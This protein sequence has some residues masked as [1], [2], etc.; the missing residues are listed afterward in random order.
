MPDNALYRPAP[1][2]NALAPN[3]Y[4]QSLNQQYPWTAGIDLNIINS[5]AKGDK[6][7][8]LEFYPAD[9]RDNPHPGRP[10]IEIFDPSM[11]ATDLMGEVLSHHLPKVDPTVAQF[12]AKILSSMTPQQIK[13]IQGDY[14]N[15]KRAGLVDKGDDLRTWIGKQG[16]DS[17]F[18]GYPTGQWPSSVYTPE[19]KQIYEQLRSYLTAKFGKK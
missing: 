8:K 10:T 17:F 2:Q 12:R 16:G 15:E 5:T 13:E 11:S 6:S 3:S 19:Q 1:E 9:E 7:R 14:E 18:R 4:S